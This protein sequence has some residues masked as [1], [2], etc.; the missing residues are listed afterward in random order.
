MIEFAGKKII[1]SLVKDTGSKRRIEKLL[2]EQNHRS[3]EAEREIAEL[4]RKLSELERPSRTADLVLRMVDRIAQEHRKQQAKSKQLLNPEIA[5]LMD[6][7]VVLLKP[8]EST[9]NGPRIEVGPL[10]DC[11]VRV[12]E[13]I[14]R[15]Q[16]AISLRTQVT[17]PTA[18]PAEEFESAICSLLKIAIDAADFPNETHRDRDAGLARKNDRRRDF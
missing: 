13:Y 11:Y 12:F 10:V 8:L 2:I 17:P 3:A 7:A 5:A 6:A 14:H 15:G 18:F 4:R 16:V 1:Q 9:N